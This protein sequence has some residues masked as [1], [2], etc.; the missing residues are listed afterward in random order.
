[1][2]A[3]LHFYMMQRN[4]SLMGLSLLSFCAFAVKNPSSWNKTKV[5]TES[6]L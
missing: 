1:M 5:C 2:K 4:N 3:E 6:V